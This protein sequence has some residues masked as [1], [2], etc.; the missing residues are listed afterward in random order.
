MSCCMWYR[1]CRVLFAEMEDEVL[2]EV[3]Q[4]ASDVQQAVVHFMEHDLY[5]QDT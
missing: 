1:L 3:E 2:T 4:S 5:R